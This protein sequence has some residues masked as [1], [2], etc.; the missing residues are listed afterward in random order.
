[1]FS[2][3]LSECWGYA[4]VAPLVVPG[5]LMAAALIIALRGRD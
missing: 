3:G 2:E 4:V 1:M 5:V